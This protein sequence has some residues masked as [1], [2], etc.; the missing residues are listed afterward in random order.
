VEPLGDEVKRELDRFGPQGAI[1][2]TVTA[3]PA[4]V[5]SEIARAAWP[6]RF[7]RD[8]TLVVHTR[9]AIWAFEL[10]HRAAEIRER[11]E[12]VAALKFVPGPL[13]E[14]VPE[15]PPATP[16]GSP[17]PS[18]EQSEQAARWAAE[19]EDEDLRKI[20]TKAV[21][22]SLARAPNDRSF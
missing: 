19:I 14:S 12:G 4:A 16:P 21:A 17:P 6:A 2:E 15:P 18:T 5:G 22:M 13:P 20:V 1:G 7:Q 10:T 9:D 11:L 3:W 8:G